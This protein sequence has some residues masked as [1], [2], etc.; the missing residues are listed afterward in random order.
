[1]YICN[2]D[3]RCWSEPGEGM[4]IAQ[5]STNCNGETED[6]DNIICSSCEFPAFW[7]EY[8][9]DYVYCDDHRRRNVEP[10]STPFSQVEWIKEA[11][12]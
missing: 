3:E 1:M 11:L 5:A 2:A 6:L 10:V 4:F 9:D 7:C 12:K 8:C